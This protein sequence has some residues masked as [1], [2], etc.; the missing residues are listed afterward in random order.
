MF[1]KL[2]WQLGILNKGLFAVLLHLDLLDLAN[3]IYSVI[4]K[5]TPKKH[6]KLFLDNDINA[7]I[8]AIKLEAAVIR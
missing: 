2:Y 8:N 1:V 6:L 4:F 3:T 5:Y 7:N